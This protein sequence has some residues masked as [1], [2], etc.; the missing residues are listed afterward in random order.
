MS[1]DPLGTLEETAEKI[2]DKRIQTN[3]ELLTEILMILKR[4]EK[5]LEFMNDEQAGD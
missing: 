2:S 5:H 1:Y 4:I 3:N